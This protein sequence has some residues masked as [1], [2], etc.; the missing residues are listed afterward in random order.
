[1]LPLN[2][3]SPAALSEQLTRSTPPANGSDYS[4][5]LFTVNQSSGCGLATLMPLSDVQLQSYAAVV[6]TSFFKGK[7]IIYPATAVPGSSNDLEIQ[8]IGASIL[9]EGNASTLV[10]RSGEPKTST[11][12]TF[13]SHIKAQKS[14][15]VLLDGITFSYSYSSGFSSGTA[16]N[17]SL[18]AL[19]V[20]PCIDGPG[21]LARVLYASPPLGDY[22]FSACDDYTPQV[23]SGY[24]AGGDDI[25]SGDVTLEQAFSNCTSIPSCMGFTYNGPLTPSPGQTV[26]AYLKSAINFVESP[27]WQT[28]VSSRVSETSSGKVTNHSS[29][30]HSHGVHRF[31]FHRGNHLGGQGPERVTQAASPKKAARIQTRARDPSHCFSPP[32]HVRIA[33]GL[34]LD[35]SEG[36]QLAIMFNNNDR[37]VRLLLPIDVTIT[38]VSPG[39]GVPLA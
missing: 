35:A 33:S 1:M 19:H 14:A 3:T 9:P 15:K 17:F 31:H 20:N 7:N 2:G 38:W 10:L 16:S 24:L 4:D 25:W 37:N 29:H 6:K 11:S 8:K 36:V 23:P 18:V 32:V 34:E 27:G 26:H 12:V 39:P 21:P 22:P 13:F 28:Y 5:I 30:S